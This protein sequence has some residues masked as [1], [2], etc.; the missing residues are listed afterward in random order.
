MLVL[1]VV[2]RGTRAR[3]GRLPGR[4]L[5]WRAGSGGFPDPES[6]VIAPYPVAVRRE[7][8]HEVCERLVMLN[9]RM[10]DSCV[11]ERGV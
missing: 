10:L 7:L 8:A 3:M 5:P 9:L 11:R 6:L 1:Y 2:A 4:G